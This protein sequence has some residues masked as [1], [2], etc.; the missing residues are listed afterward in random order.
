[1][2][3]VTPNDGCVVG[4][5]ACLVFGLAGWAVLIGLTIWAAS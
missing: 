4:A 5:L 1:M 3:D 2:R